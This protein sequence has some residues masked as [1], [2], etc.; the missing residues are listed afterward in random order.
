MDSRTSELTPKAFD[1]DIWPWLQRK[2]AGC[3]LSCVPL[4]TQELILKQRHQTR[5][6][7]QLCDQFQCDGLITLHPQIHLPFL[8]P[9]VKPS[10][11]SASEPVLE[12][13]NRIA[14]LFGQ[15]TQPVLAR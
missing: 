13:F 7:V 6:S 10:R 1:Q 12:V 9:L 15:N 3:G 4:W 8:S 11:R 14:L 2:F 5:V